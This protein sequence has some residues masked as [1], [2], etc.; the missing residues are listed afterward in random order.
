MLDVN[1][2]N[3]WCYTTLSIFY[4]EKACEIVLIL[5]K[6]YLWMFLYR[7]YIHSKHS[8]NNTVSFLICLKL[9]QK[10][11]KRKEMQH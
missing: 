9:Y 11:T 3:A 10:E 2:H 7:F 8:Q 6:K 1:I 4:F 5:E